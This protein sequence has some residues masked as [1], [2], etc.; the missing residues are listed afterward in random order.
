MAIIDKQL[1]RCKSVVIRLEHALPEN[2]TGEITVPVAAHEIDDLSV[3]LQNAGNMINVA[4]NLNE[5][6]NAA[7][8]KLGRA[9]AVLQ[10][11]PEAW[12]EY[13]AQS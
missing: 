12:A 13:Q 7:D 11:H 6:L 9:L 4:R 10:R 2:Y 1:E 5:L 8:V 3:F